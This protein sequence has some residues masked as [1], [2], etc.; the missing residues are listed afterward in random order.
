MLGEGKIWKH[1]V[2]TKYKPS[3][4]IFCAQGVGASTFWKG[5]VWASKA[6]NFGYRWSFGNGNLIRFWEDTWFG[7]SPLSVQVWGLYFICSEQCETVK[8]IWDGE[9]IKLSFRRS[10]SP[11][12]M[13]LWYELEVIVSSVSFNND[14]DS[15]VW[16]YT[17][18]GSYTTTSL[19]AIINY[20]GVTPIFIPFVWKLVV[21][22]RIHIFPWLASYN[23]IMTRDNLQKRN[24]NK[25]LHCVF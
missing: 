7:T 9:T 10:F 8:Q 15:L 5:V 17:A 3:P 19:Y 14:T 25:P 18:S 16:Q 6:V 20:R 12:M 2:D 13:E 21:P 22:P 24:M 11:R 1:I 23:K 4:N